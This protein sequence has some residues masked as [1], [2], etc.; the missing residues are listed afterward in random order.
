[1]IVLPTTTAI[2]RAR[3]SAGIATYNPSFAFFYGDE[4]VGA[5]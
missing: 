1:M 3:L 2:L 4:P 5:G